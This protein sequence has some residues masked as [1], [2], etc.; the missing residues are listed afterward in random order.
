MKLKKM[1]DA[2]NEPMTDD[3]KSK[4][5]RDRT[6]TIK[7]VENDSERDFESSQGEDDQ[8]SNSDTSKI[9]KANMKSLGVGPSN[10]TPQSLYIEQLSPK[11]RKKF[12]LVLKKNLKTRSAMITLGKPR[13]LLSP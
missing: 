12:D 4:I 8:K 2:G 9:S 7:E 5:S 11:S 1:M 10:F 6:E 3:Q 13:Q